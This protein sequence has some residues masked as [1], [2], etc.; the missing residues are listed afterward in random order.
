MPSG[1]T[2]PSDIGQTVS[3]AKVISK[4]IC[5]NN[6]VSIIPGSNDPRRPSQRS[7]QND[8]VPLLAYASVSVLP[9][10]APSWY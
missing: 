10:V 4:V 6:P 7:I 1:K 2:R 3:S 8:S 5:G 9:K